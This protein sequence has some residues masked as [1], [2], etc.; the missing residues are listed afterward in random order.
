MHGL[1]VYLDLKETETRSVTKELDFHKSVYQR[2][3]ILFYKVCLSEQNLEIEHV[4][5]GLEEKRGS[6][7]RDLQGIPK[8]ILPLTQ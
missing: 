3:V 2:Y 1:S 4:V 5:K 6:L 8:Y 7:T